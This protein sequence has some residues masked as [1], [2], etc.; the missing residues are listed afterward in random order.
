MNLI[1]STL[2]VLKSNVEFLSCIDNKEYN[3]SIA[4]LSN[5]TIGQHFR[6]L[7]ELYQCLFDQY[8]SARINYA[9]R[10]RD[11][12][13]ETNKEIAIS[14]IENL[15]SRI[16]DLDFEKKLE[17]ALDTNEEEFISTN[18]KRE[19]LYNL[20]H[21]IHHNAMIKIGIH[22]LNKNF[23][24]SA[25]FGVAPSTIEYQRKSSKRLQ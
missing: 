17:L 7:I 14:C 16:N 4:A 18:V 19:L 25:A 6:H 3:T 24:C 2:E 5:S 21:A 12:S 1:S 13:I 20:E 9:L 10:K 22:V 11:K 23:E 8:S 15:M